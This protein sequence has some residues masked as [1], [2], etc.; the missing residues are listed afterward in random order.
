MESGLNASGRRTYTWVTK[1]IFNNMVR[2]TSPPPPGWLGTVDVASGPDEAMYGSYSAS[3]DAARYTTDAAG[4]LVVMS[5]RF[6]EPLRID[7][8]NPRSLA[9]VGSSRTI[10][11]QGWPLLGDVHAAANGDF[12]VLVGRDN[13]RERADLDV[14]AVRRYNSAWKL[15]GTALLKGDA[16]QLLEGIRTPF[17]AAAPDMHL[18]GNRLIVHLS[19]LM[20]RSSDGLNH[21]S[22]LTFEVNTTTMKATTFEE[23]HGQWS[24]PYVSHSFN[25]FVT[26]VGDQLV[27]VDHG[28][29]YPRSIVMNVV[30]EAVPSVTEHELMLFNGEV[31]DNFTGASVTGVVTDGSRVVV[32]GN[33]IPH[34][35]A[36]NG[37]MNEDARRNVFT[38]T[39]DPATGEKSTKWLTSVSATSG[40]YVSEPRITKI[41]DGRFAVMFTV[42]RG[43]AT[44]LEYRLIDSLATV[45]GSASLPGV[46]FPSGAEPIKVGSQLMWL[47]AGESPASVYALDLADPARPTLAKR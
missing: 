22:N 28:D 25:N 9:R 4:N 43:N 38:I 6:G 19:R 5:R 8:F 20:F 10:P 11:M 29:A 3:P 21:Q 30:D 37:T 15:Q 14:V 26:A 44:T 33:S 39:V 17:R 7:I 36:P 12:Y 31:G 35:N 24:T 32:V 40:D 27:F 34:I 13:P 45:K 41:S 18:E 47:T 46:P 1:E 42:E 23:L 16:S 2:F